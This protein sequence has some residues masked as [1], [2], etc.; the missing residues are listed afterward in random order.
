MEDDVATENSG[1]YLISAVICEKILQEKDETIS[2]IRI[3]DCLAVTVSTLGSPETMPTTTVN[4]Y[5]LIRV[6]L[7]VLY[8]RIGPSS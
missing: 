3:V 5:M 1:P 7:R 4:L 2:I 6:P 8:Q